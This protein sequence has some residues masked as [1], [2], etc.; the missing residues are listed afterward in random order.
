MVRLA[1]AVYQGVVKE[2]YQVRRWE[3]AN[4]Q[5]YRFRQEELKE[6]EEKYKK[7]WQ[8]EGEVAGEGIRK[9]YL[10]K[11]V[12]GYLTRGATNPIRYVNR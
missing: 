11:D 10:G 8:F 1:L 2:V 6:Q 7:R 9:R 3:P 5:S 12:S 4:W